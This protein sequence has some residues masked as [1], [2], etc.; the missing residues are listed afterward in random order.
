VPL[1]KTRRKKRKGKEKAEKAMTRRGKAT[2]LAYLNNVTGIC[3]Q[4]L[5]TINQHRK[6]KKGKG[7]KE[8]NKRKRRGRRRANKGQDNSNKNT[9]TKNDLVNLNKY[10]LLLY[11]EKRGGG[12][13]GEGWIERIKEPA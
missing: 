5:R 12:G 1:I 6:K 13:K 2:G 8:K 4:L 3:L 10:P 7:R 11:Q 9:L